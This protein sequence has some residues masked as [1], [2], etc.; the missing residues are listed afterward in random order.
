MAASAQLYP[1]V[2][3]MRADEARS[4]VCSLLSPV[5]QLQR[6]PLGRALNRLA[7]E[8]LVATVDLPPWD[9]AAVD[10]YAL[11]G[12]DISPD[13]PTHLTVIG[14]AAAGHPFVQPLGKREAARIFTGAPLPLGA[15][16]VVMQEVCQID[17]DAISVPAGEEKHSHCRRRG[18]DV[19]AGTPVLA[20]GHR[21]QP[22]DI[23]LAAALGHRELAV[24]SRLRV[25]LFSTGDEVREPGTSLRAGDIWD[26]NRWLLGGLLANLDCD[27]TDL[28]ILPDD[29]RIIEAA[30]SAAAHDHD[31]LVTSGGMSVGSE[32]HLRTV[33][34][35]RGTMDVWRLAIKPGKPVGF[36]D[37]DACPIL[38]LPGNPAAAMVTFLAFGRPIVLR[39]AG[40]RDE[41]PFSIRVP[42]GHGYAKKPGRREYVP[43]RLTRTSGSSAFIPLAKLGPAMLL[44][45]TQMEGFAVMDEERERLVQGDVVEFIPLAPLLS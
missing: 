25:A 17:G 45:L 28:G 15:D 21:L 12:D 6:V 8:G 38:A 35:R 32:D 34:R 26:A 19:F 2:D 20:T 40:G 11:R 22:Q 3:V 9:S 39:L 24:F 23:A 1:E 41:P 29:P 16:T 4:L 13:G 36:G 44:P 14:R 43:G 10:G 5:T 33:I 31:L 7:A 18:E 30:L 37:I 42:L 27:M